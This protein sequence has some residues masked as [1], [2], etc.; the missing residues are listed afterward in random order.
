MKCEI[1]FLIHDSLIP[2]R[3]QPTCHPP[4]HVHGADVLPGDELFNV[5]FQIVAL[6]LGH[7]LQDTQDAV[8]AVAL[9]GSHAVAERSFEDARVRW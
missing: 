5:T 4:E 3:R 2:G 9:A 6:G 1:D 8:H 7:R